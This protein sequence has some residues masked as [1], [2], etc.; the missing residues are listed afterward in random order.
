MVAALLA[1][2]A[3]VEGRDLLGRSALHCAARWGRSPELVFALL[4]AGAKLTARTRE[5]ET[6]AALAEQNTALRHTDAW[7]RLLEGR[8]A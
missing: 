2:D 3:S 7:F 8:Y 4:D 1:A 5:R 6:V